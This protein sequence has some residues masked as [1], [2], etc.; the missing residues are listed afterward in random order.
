MKAVGKE[1]PQQGGLWNAIT[2]EEFTD[3]S[4]CTPGAVPI[5]LPQAHEPYIA[6]GE[7]HS[8]REGSA[9]E[10]GD[11]FL[12]A[13][14]ATFSFDISGLGMPYTY[15]WHTVLYGAD[16]QVLRESR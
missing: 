14:V 6:T 13:A 9:E 3:G 1:V 4:T 8:R 2:K 15:C 10:T 7:V 11:T 16:S 5:Q 12:E